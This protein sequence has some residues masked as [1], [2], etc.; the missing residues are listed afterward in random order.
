MLAS[1]LPTALL[2]SLPLPS[3]SL[4]IFILLC[5]VFGTASCPSKKSLLSFQGQQFSFA[6]PHQILSL[7]Y[8]LLSIASSS[9]PS[10]SALR[11]Q[12]I[13]PPHLHETLFVSKSLPHSSSSC[14]GD[15]SARLHPPFHFQS[16]RAPP[17]HER[18]LLR[19][20][21]NAAFL[22]T[23]SL[24]TGHNYT[25]R[26]VRAGIFSLFHSQ[27][28]LPKQRAWNLDSG[29]RNIFLAVV[30]TVMRFTS[31]ARTR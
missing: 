6:E 11:V 15:A 30:L 29:N 18:V 2:L 24:S 16:S 31:A 1:W 4:L 25:L 5:A 27:I 20:Y 19:L 17:T 26:K 23:P 28:F 22:F 14:S 3:F 13:T 8:S 12:D 7:F 21:I 9:W 10:A